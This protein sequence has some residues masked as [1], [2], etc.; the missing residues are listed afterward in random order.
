MFQHSPVEFRC[1]KGF[2]IDGIGDLVLHFWRRERFEM[3]KLFA[4]PFAGEIGRFPVPIAKEQKWR[5]GRGFFAHEE[6][7]HMR[8]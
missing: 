8:A 2:L 3:S 5:L 1:F 6:H 4:A 7:W